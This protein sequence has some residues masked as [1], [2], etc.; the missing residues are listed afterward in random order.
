MGEVDCVNALVSVYQI[1]VIGKNGIGLIR[2]IQLMCAKVL[3]SI[4]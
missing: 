2:P 1:D 4:C 3:H